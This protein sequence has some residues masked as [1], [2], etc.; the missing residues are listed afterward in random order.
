MILN[1]K[2][3]VNINLRNTKLEDLEFVLALEN[4]PENFKFIG[5]WTS[6]EHANSLNNKNIKHL[7]VEESDSLKKLGYVIIQGLNNP[8][9]SLELMRI[10]IDKKSKGTG[11]KVLDLIKKIAFVENNMNRL[12]LEVLTYNDRAINAYK[13]IGFTVEGKLRESFYADN[14]FHSVYLLSILKSE[15]ESTLN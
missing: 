11:K 8:Y 13:Q 1:K 15:F 12:W 5:G 6:T 4:T 3:A 2:I 7:I 10:V 9:K 14:K